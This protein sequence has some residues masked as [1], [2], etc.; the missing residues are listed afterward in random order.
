M[1][2]TDP[3]I[4]PN[5]WTPLV[6]ITCHHRQPQEFGLVGIVGIYTCPITIMVSTL[7]ER[8]ASSTRPSVTHWPHLYAKLGCNDI[9]GRSFSVVP[10]L[11][12]NTK[13]NQRF[14]PMPNWL[15]NGCLCLC[16]TETGAGWRRLPPPDGGR[17]HQGRH[18]NWVGFQVAMQ[19]QGS[20]GSSCID[21]SLLEVWIL[22]GSSL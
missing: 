12:T 10:H 19:L 7:L 18:T 21:R 2:L 6:P 11:P 4:E 13:P 8:S 5:S 14:P 3:K 20:N 16:Q 22:L 9:A 1:A 15:A 17:S